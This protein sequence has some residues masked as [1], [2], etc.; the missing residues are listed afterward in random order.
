[1]RT[2][3]THGRVVHSQGLQDLDLLVEGHRILALGPWS[4][5]GPADLTLDAAGA[6][7]L[8]GLIDL[9]T[10]LDDRIGRFDLADSYA[11]AG[12]I[13]LKEGLTTLAAFI[14]QEPGE[15]LQAAVDRAL[16]K[17][18]AR[19]RCQTTWHLTPTRWD[20]DTWS[21]LA[22]LSSRG[23][24]TVKVYTTYREAGLLL[25]P[26]QLHII[27]PRLAA[28][29]LR[30]LVHCEDDACLA[31]AIPGQ[32]LSKPSSLPRLRPEEAEVSA[33]TRV[34]ELAREARLPLHVVHVSSLEAAQRIQS[35]RPNQ[36]VTCETCPQYLWLDPSWLS[37]P[38]G[39]RWLCAP[40]LRENREPFREAL[41][42]G[43]F[44]CLATDHC[45]FL[46]KDKDAWDG[47]DI[48]RV[49]HGLPGLGSLVPLAWKLFEEA[50]DRAALSVARLLSETPARILGLQHRKGRLE[51]G[52]DADMVVLDPR[53]P[54]RPLKS[55]LAEVHEPYP[56]FTTRLQ[57]RHVLM[58]GQVQVRDGARWGHDDSR[59]CVLPLPS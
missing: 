44:D 39:H 3:L 56:G 6:Y 47:Q 52:L 33:V 19:A 18:Q 51:P 27:F 57:A 8:P 29:G 37:L 38:Q 21:T 2:L 28:L 40:P 17:A 54:R 59:A 4:S 48:R 55:S 10:H 35:A 45:A 9:H 25:D 13:A 7:V 49:G 46:A 12:E 41:R 34:L 11:T 42:E 5:L 58:A 31:R 43:L 50:P 23:F 20:E 30:V 22:R 15:T 32:D 1:M 53:G 24:R 26:D 14:T 36:D 16:V